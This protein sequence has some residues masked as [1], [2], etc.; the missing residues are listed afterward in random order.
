MPLPMMT[1]GSLIA[2]PPPPEGEPEDATL[3]GR[4][5][6]PVGLADHVVRE[7]AI[8]FGPG[9]RDVAGPVQA[10]HAPDGPEQSLPDDRIMFG[11]DTVV[12][13]TSGQLSGGRQH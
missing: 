12:Y 3:L 6:P 13:V 2:G 1:S 5:L 8:G 7:H 9:G 11:R 4:H 10:K